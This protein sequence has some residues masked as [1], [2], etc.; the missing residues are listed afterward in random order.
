MWGRHAPEVPAAAASAAVPTSWSFWLV[1]LCPFSPGP[2]D[3]EC[4][5]LQLLNYFPQ[6]VIFR[7]VP[8]IYM[9]AIRD[10]NVKS[11]S[12]QRPSSLHDIQKT[13]DTC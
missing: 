3:R 6:L 12:A 13:Q 11:V 9:G 2:H 7:Y 4:V 5:H 8:T 10:V 1:P